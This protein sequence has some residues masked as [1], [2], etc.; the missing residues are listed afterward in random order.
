MHTRTE[1]RQSSDIKLEHLRYFVNSDVFTIH[2]WWGIS[3]KNSIQSQNPQT[4]IGNG[5]LA[6]GVDKAVA[7]T[8]ATS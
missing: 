2:L 7:A 1:P 4:T 5:Y 6:A 3:S 8:A